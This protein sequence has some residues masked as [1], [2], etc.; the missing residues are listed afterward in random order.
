MQADWTEVDGI[1]AL[2]AAPGE[3]QGPLQGSLAFATGRR[4]ETLVNGGINHLVEH[5]ALHET[6]D[7][8][9]VFNGSVDAVTTTFWA[10][11]SP[12]QVVEFLGR[13][14]KSLGGLPLDRLDDERRVLE[15][16][17]NRRGEP[18]NVPADLSERFG[19][20]GAGLLWWSE[21]GLRGLTPEAL[22]DWVR[23]RF[24]A[25]NAVL[26]FSR[27]LPPG[28]DLGA[29]PRGPRPAP[30]DLP[31]SLTGARAF[32]A[33]ETPRISLSILGA[34]GTGSSTGMFLAQRRAREQLRGA[35]LSYSI[36]LASVRIAPR[37]VLLQLDADAGDESHVSV[38][39]TLADV[40]ADLA[41]S[42][43]DPDELQTLHEM[44][45][46]FDEHPQQR[47]ADLRSA[48]MHRVLA[49]KVVVPSDLDALLDAETPETVRDGMRA[50][51]DTTLLV[52]PAALSDEVPGWTQ[53]APWSTEHLG[54]RD[55]A[56][57]PGREQGTLEVGA[58]GVTWRLDGNHW[59]AIR[60]TDVEA[61][62]ALDS[63]S[64]R[65]IGTTG[66]HVSVV[67]WC[68]QGG[69]VLADLVDAAVDPA[70]IVRVGEGQLHYEDPDDRTKVDVRWL[71]TIANAR[72]NRREHDYASLV[73][74]TDGVF[75]VYGKLPRDARAA[76]REALLASDARNC[77][78]PQGSITR[79]DLR[80]KQLT[81]VGLRTWTLTIDT[82]DGEQRRL[83]F[84]DEQQRSIAMVQF[85][86]LLGARFTRP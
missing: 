40:V 47:L 1:P 63:G 11:G 77:W 38:A 51:L 85:P 60:W 14:A 50:A 76:D 25:E 19:P 21:F 26:W 44:R 5:L 3:V 58:D 31:K 78:I 13:L 32:V 16:E 84:T 75:V 18:S 74:D 53:H 72:H 82:D 24:V 86:R 23:T 36:G 81:P 35:A 48:A 64:R 42:G 39:R 17:A 66:M 80:I 67:P 20:H 15:I 10:Q 79:V 34:H 49:Q 71:A 22:D 61:L 12:E 43:P 37:H 69:E 6:G 4:D 65:V 70:R 57:I 28:L 56:P 7:V 33:M 41:E 83:Y 9:Y 30:A 52:G 2:V 8:P 27:P 68:W 29:I 54:G 55:F 46:Q 73:V 62:L 59:R 45:R